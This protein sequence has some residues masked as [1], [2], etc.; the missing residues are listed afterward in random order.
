MEER[1]RELCIRVKKELEE[2]N[3]DEARE[4]IT[5]AM[6]LFP[7]SAVPH[8]LMGI[9]YEKQYCHIEGMKHFRAAWDLDPTFI[10][11]RYNM[12]SFGSFEGKKICFYLDEE[13][14]NEIVKPK[15]KFVFD[16]LGIAHMEEIK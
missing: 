10:P 12:N 2:Y 5:E 11:A 9:W 4:E 13:C 15:K 6:K 1:L 16:E 14:E 7:D 3:Y 8:N